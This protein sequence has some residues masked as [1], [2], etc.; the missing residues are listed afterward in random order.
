VTFREIEA[1][2]GRHPLLISHPRWVDGLLE[3]I[4]FTIEGMCPVRWCYLVKHLLKKIRFTELFFFFYDLFIH[5]P[6]IFF[7]DTGKLNNPK[8]PANKPLTIT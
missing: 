8:T 7:E 1:K 4:L 5:G 2:A 6:K 3:S